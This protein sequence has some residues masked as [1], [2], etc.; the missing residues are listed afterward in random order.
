MPS[1][2]K[3]K[4]HLKTSPEEV[5]GYLSTSEGRKKYWAE[6]AEELN[7][8]IH[9]VFANGQKYRS[10]ILLAKPFSY[11]QIEYF[12]SIVRFDLMDDGKGGTDLVM[13]NS[14]VPEEDYRTNYAGWVSLLL[15]LK[16]MVDFNVD[17]RNHDTKRTWDQL[18][19]DN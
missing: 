12:N 8:Y 19:I 11:Y 7:G 18:Y 16:A 5:Y 1:E 15:T 6:N 3:W 2:I 14:K 4:L 17:I 13:L 9:F 10:K